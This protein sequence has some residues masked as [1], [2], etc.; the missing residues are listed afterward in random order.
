MLGAKAVMK[1]RCQKT[2]KVAAQSACEELK[3]TKIGKTT[4]GEEIDPEEIFEKLM[5]EHLGATG[6]RRRMEKAAEEFVDQVWL[7]VQEIISQR[8]FMVE[9]MEGWWIF[10]RPVLVPAKIEM[11]NDHEFSIHLGKDRWLSV[12][13][14]NGISVGVYSYKELGKNDF[15][16]EGISQLRSVAEGI[17]VVLKELIKCSQI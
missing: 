10:R 8:D 4:M 7:G 1:N 6:S 12:E 16:C 17:E 3:S 5:E 15:K 11:D 14:I 13:I 9:K 2:A